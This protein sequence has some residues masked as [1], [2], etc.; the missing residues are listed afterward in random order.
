MV[1]FEANLIISP[2]IE[3]G[4]I[5]CRSEGIVYDLKRTVDGN[6]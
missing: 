4:S 2:L 5:H 6:G 3:Y 1:S